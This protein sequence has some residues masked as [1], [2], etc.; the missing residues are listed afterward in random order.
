MPKNAE[1][2]LKAKIRAGKPL[3]GCYVTF[4]SPDVVE[5]FA[6]AGMDYVIIDLQHASPDWQTLAQLSVGVIVLLALL[7]MVWTQW[8]ARRRDPWERQR[9]R[10]IATLQG[11]GLDAHAHMGPRSLAQLLRRQHGAGAEPLAQLLDALDRQRYA[12]GAQR[13]APRQW[14]RNF[15][16]ATG[17]LGRIPSN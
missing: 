9:A 6:H 7:G 8:D 2:G 11:L 13:L 15:R 16:R 10:L 4:P 3:I 14:W 5:L 17:K 12:P 1:P